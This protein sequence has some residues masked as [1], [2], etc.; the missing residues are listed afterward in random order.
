MKQP[1]DNQMTFAF[2]DGGA[3]GEVDPV[4][5]NPVPPGSE[6]ENVRDDVDAKLSE[7]EYVIPANVVNFYGIDKFRKMIQKAE[8]ELE[9]MD[10]EGQIGGEPVAEEGA[11]PVEDDLPFSVEELQVAEDTPPLEMATGGVVYNPNAGMTAGGVETRTYT[12]DAGQKRGFIF[13]NGMPITAI[14]PGWY[15]D[16]MANRKAMQGEDPT[17]ESAAVKSMHSSDEANNL[18]G[19]N[20]PDG[21]KKVHANVEEWTTDDFEKL[22]G[23]QMIV[24]TM[25]RGLGLAGPG[26]LLIGAAMRQGN[27]HTVSR[28][29]DEMMARIN[30]PDTPQEDRDRLQKVYSKFNEQEDDEGG[31]IFGGGIME[32]IFGKEGF[33]GSLFGGK[34]PETPTGISPFKSTRTGASAPASTGV[35]HGTHKS[36]SNIA[37]TRQAPTVSPRPASRPA[38]TTSTAT[39][40]AKNIDPKTNSGGFDEDK[41]SWG[42]GPMYKGGYVKRRKK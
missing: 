25:S 4:S 21:E 38:Q 27:K 31:G 14:P 5:G 17:V 33:F 1:L 37:A 15:P 24:D 8:Q 20:A 29:M 22:A 3:V 9:Q 30:N 35:S 34:K 42:V 11:D 6:P 18:L 7:G 12:N 23:Q 39:V 40:G 26:G 32:N 2:M 19:K 41:G 16:T 10:A 28:A 36:D 13:F